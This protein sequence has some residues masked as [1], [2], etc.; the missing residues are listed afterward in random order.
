MNKKIVHSVFEDVARRFPRNI[1]V[2]ED[3]RAFTYEE[4]RQRAEEAARAL[5]ELGVGERAEGKPAEEDVVGVMLPPGADYVS[6]ILGTAMAGGVFL[7]LDAEFPAARFQHLLERTTPAAL[8]TREALESRVRKILDSDSPFFASN[9]RSPISDSELVV[10]GPRG[11]GKDK[12]GR[13]AFEARPYPGDRR[14]AEP[15]DGLYLVYTSGSTGEPKIILG[16]HKGLSH[17]IHWEMKEFRLD[18]SVR[19]SLLAPVTFDVSLRDIFAPLLSGGT[20]CVPDPE[21]R[22]N[23][24]RL[25]QWMDESQV[26]L[27]H[28]VPSLFRLLLRELEGEA[29]LKPYPAESRPPLKS[30]QRI[31]LAG[32]VLYGR[33]VTR[34]MDLF[35]DRVELV[36]LYGPSESTLAKAFH[37]I[38]GRPE[39]PRRAIPLGLPISNTALLVLEDGR[40]CRPGE[41][42]EIFIKTPFLTKGYYR[43]P[44]G[45][46]SSFVQN[47]LNPGARDTVYRT[48]DLGRYLPDRSVEFTGRRD[49]QVKV[50]GIRV[51]PAEIERAL[52]S[53]EGVEQGVVTAREGP[54]HE[55]RLVAYYT[56]RRNAPAPHGVGAGLDVRPDPKT[57]R[58]YL[59]ATLPPYMLPS[60]FIRLEDFPLNRHGKV[61]VAALPSPESLREEAE[62][63]EAPAD[64]VEAALESMW[65]EVL[66]IPRASVT[67][68]FFET[69]GNSLK[70]LRILSR[71]YRDFG[72]EVSVRDFFAR[73]TI[74]ELAEAVRSIGADLRARP[75]TVEEA[76]FRNIEPLPE[77]PHYELSRAQRR[78][79]ILDRMEGGGVAYNIPGAYL[80]QGNLDRDAFRRAF[81]ALVERHESLRT[82]FVAV[83]GEPRQKILGGAGTMELADLRGE[84]SSE[85]ELEAR[86]REMARREALRPF[87][88]ATG[89]LLR[90]KVLRLD[91]ERHAVLFNMHHVVGDAWSRDVLA[92]EVLALYGAFHRGEPPPLEPLRIQYRDFAAWQNRLLESDAMDEH[93]A[94]WHEKLAGEIEPL[95]LPADRP[96]PPVQTF[97]G[98]TS[99]FFWDEE[100]TERLH[101]LSREREASLFMTLVA[102]VKAWLHRLSGREDVVVGSPIAGR[103]HPELENQIGFYVNML[104]LRDSV[105]GD[106][107]FDA[108]LERVKAT[109][110]EAYEHQIYPFDRL[111]DELRLERDM[112]HAPLFDAG[113]TL[114]Q[115][116]S[117]LEG[118]DQSLR[119]EEFPMEWGTSKLDLVLTFVE[120]RER[121]RLDVNYN[122]DLF[123]ASTIHRWAGHLRELA[124][125]AVETPREIVGRLN[126]LS[127]EEKT[128]IL[129]EFNQRRQDYPTGEAIHGL[130]QEQARRTPNRTAVVFKERRLTYRQ[131]DERAD[132]LAC[133]LREDH[134]VERESLVGVAMERSHEAVVALLGILKAGGAY[135]PLDPSYPE[136]RRRFM[137]EDSGCRVVLADK[138][139]APAAKA[140]GVERVLELEEWTASAESARAPGRSEGPPRP[141]TRDPRPDGLAYV[142]Y[143]SGSTGKPKGVMVE[144][145]GL[146]NMALDQIRSFGI[147]P[148]DR[149]LQFA[150]LSFDASLYETFMALFAGAALVVA[151]RQVIAHP[152]AF[153]AYLKAHG[154]TTV[155]LP[156]VYLSALGNRDL[157][158]LKTIVTAGEAAVAKDALRYARDKQ[159]INAYGPT[160]ASVC[161][162]FHRVDPRRE[163][164]GG[165]PAGKPVAN[166]S[167]YVVDE[168]MSPVPVGV[169]GEICVSGVGLARGYL[170]RPELTREKFPPNPFAPSPKAKAEVG[171]MNAEV[172]H[173]RHSGD[174]QAGIHD[175]ASASRLPPSALEEERLYRTGDLGRWLEDGNLELLGR[176]DHQVKVR[177]YRVEPGEIEN[178]LNEH[179]AVGEAL[180]TGRKS[181]GGVRELAA[182]FTR[183]R[184]SGISGVSVQAL[185]ELLSARLPEYMVPASFV[186]LERFPLTPNGKI[187]RKALP[188]PHESALETGTPYAAPRDEKEALLARVWEEV[189][190]RKPVG[191]DDNYFALGGDSIKAIQIVSKLNREQWKLQVVD[192][193]RSPTI[194]R[195]A[196]AM[197]PLA[198]LADQGP[199]TG[200]VPLTPIQHWFFREWRGEPHH[201]NQSA[202]LELVKPVE[203]EIL[204][205]C[206]KALQ[207]HHDALRLR[208]RFPEDEPLPVQENAGLDHP[209]GF[210]TMDLREDAQGASRMEAHAAGVQGSFD[211]A[212][213]PLFKAVLY[214]RQDGDRLLLAAHHLVVD[215]V[216]WRILLEDLG[217][218]LDQAAS[219]K[220]VQ[221]PPKTTSFAQWAKE[222]S[223]RAEGGRAR[224]APEEE[225]REE[226]PFADSGCFPLDEIPYWSR[227][228]SAS[229]PLTPRDGPASRSPS[230]EWAPGPDGEAPPGTRMADARTLARTFTKE[231]TETLLGD[232]HQAYNTTVQ[233]IL[234]TALAAAFKR[235]HGEDATLVAL[236]AHG[237]EPLPPSSSPPPQSS[238]ASSQNR[239]PELDTGRTVGWFTAL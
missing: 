13:G 36:N 69:G 42:G 63:R 170:N 57:L 72:V 156:P 141:A 210:E 198:S 192:V 135:L 113:M 94:Y 59:Q 213:G 149:V 38:Q 172:F 230:G 233:E 39:D 101:R 66:G 89:P 65:K 133:R 19:V 91:D 169:P 98:S 56:Q 50:N 23:P 127:P 10:L 5:K 82:V 76:G 28:C 54:D 204:R 178:I 34:W 117:P 183:S 68:S 128:R 225:I 157:P 18:P 217:T 78:L 200:E 111:V 137:L 136:E 106:E 102:C 226:I 164:Q 52:R 43:D 228:E 167:L 158:T 235:W 17:F 166:L 237:R 125:S 124:K 140:L 83:D 27:V 229:V 176:K 163:Y 74:R 185:R 196:P 205:T 88:L 87:D 223:T 182:Y 171:R 2:E 24:R 37:R 79:W 150:S 58:E 109:T 107:P 105:F 75:E 61:D 14:E 40:L 193:F 215:A 60:F 93:R 51:E 103:S 6:A 132:A 232:V 161:V 144:H 148:E 104:P 4:I 220:P 238:G 85:R 11:D 189:L 131:L 236:E 173:A 197:T 119:I 44:Q 9:C 209:L 84:A 22:M 203:P 208:Y 177:G 187:D 7:P 175:F 122:T 12:A 115:E 49:R 181:K 55:I 29:A 33:D 159:Y 123:N 96:R 165:I 114:H 221:L 73:P 99:R 174:L 121:L 90:V 8:V 30:L 145:R 129:V 207:D 201:F 216:S 143:T 3:G 194:A 139:H 199:V 146:V 152:D 168:R 202:L 15:D 218:A 224:T 81:E 180:V 179:P 86:A 100:L 227:V 214:R 231:E 138:E 212:T 77:Q 45:T 184:E 142:L 134:G 47:P 206:L 32:E 118:A 1:A 160:E 239:E 112:S 53:H 97:N 219:G 151:D 80:I 25:L 155:V 130:F 48:G 92:R 147:A 153:V 64:P 20:L 26:T 16:C 191:I 190:G 110:L 195:L 67:A 116:E 46:A 31:L 188:D 70:A 62:A 120:D 234:L 162:A 222:L 35:G 108:L 41:T 186:E 95:D 154:V 71:V 21:T 126:L 211:L